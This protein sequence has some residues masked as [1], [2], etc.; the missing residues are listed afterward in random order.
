MAGT[1][2]KKKRNIVDVTKDAVVPG[3]GAKSLFEGVT[4][5]INEALDLR[6]K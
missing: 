6:S 3:Q 4:R 1:T 2:K 5:K